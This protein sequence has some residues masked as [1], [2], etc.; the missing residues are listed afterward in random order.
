LLLVRFFAGHAADG[1]GQ[2]LQP[3]L[4]DLATAFDAEA[5]L[6]GIEAHQR[7][8]DP[9]ERFPLHLNQGDFDVF[10]DIRLR[11][12]GFVQ[13]IGRPSRGRVVDSTLKH[14]LHLALAVAQH[15]L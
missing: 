15:R 7:F 8:L 10:L 5:V 4:R 9:P 11:E 2:R 13:P 3:L 12:L 14:V 6:S 1:K